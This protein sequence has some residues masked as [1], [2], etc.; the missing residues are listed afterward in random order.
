[1]IHFRLLAK[2]TG[3]TFWLGSCAFVCS[4]HA[5][6]SSSGKLAYGVDRA[7]IPDAVSKIK[8][9]ILLGFTSTLQSEAALLKPFLPFSNNSLEFKIPF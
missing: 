4:A 6:Q 8:V 5:P 9:A 7:N 1:M 3:L 2:L